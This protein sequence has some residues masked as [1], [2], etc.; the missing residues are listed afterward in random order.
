M[1]RRSVSAAGTSEQHQKKIMKHSHGGFAGKTLINRIEIQMDKRR[2]VL[3][4]I[5]VKWPADNAMENAAAFKSEEY[6]LNKGRYE[7]FAATLAILRSSSVTE[8]IN[9][10]NERLGIE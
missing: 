8:E 4:D 7:G 5:V 9:R 3:E 2:K 6:L 10:S 1:A